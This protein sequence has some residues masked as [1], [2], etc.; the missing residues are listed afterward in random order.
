MG[1]KNHPIGIRLGITRRSCSNWYTTDSEYVFFVKE[2]EYIR[3]YLLRTRRHCII[4]EVKIERLG[5]G[6]RLRISAAQVRPLVG[7][8]GELLEKLHYD[9]QKECQN[10]RIDYY[11]H[12]GMLKTNDELIE[13]PE[14]QIFVRQLVRPREDSQCL[15]DFIVVELEKRIPFRRVLRIAQERAQNLGRVSGLR[16]QVSGRLNGAEIA[17]TE[18]IRKGRVPLHTFSANLDYSYKTARTI[19][20]LLGVKV[21]IFRQA[22]DYRYLFY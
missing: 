12:S 21:W 9:L 17:R 11:Q 14:I 18:W 20:G 6:M 2:D 22:K 8:E 15:A 1:Q 7:L 3:N 10:L 13:K 16:F 5:M 19:Y 4:S